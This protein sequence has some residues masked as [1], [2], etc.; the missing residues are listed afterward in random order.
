MPRS[1]EQHVRIAVRDQVLGGHE[2]LLD[3]RA[4]TALQQHG[5]SAAAERFQQREVLHVAGPDLHDVGVVGDQLHVAVAHDFGD[6]EQAGRV[7]GFLQQLQAVDFHALEIVGRGARLV[8]AAPQD[9]RAGGR[10]RFGRLH[11]LLLG[12]NRAGTRHDDELV[13][14]DFEIADSHLR[15]LLLEFLADEFVGR[16]NADGPFNAGSG[17]QGLEARGHVAHPHH[18]N[19]HPLLAFDRV[20]SIAKIANALAD[21]IYFRLGSVRPHRDNHENVLFKYKNPLFR[22]GWFLLTC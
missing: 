17:F 15:A 10:H 13:A 6:D 20:N 7:L 3:G 22:V 19:H 16:G 8:G 18:A 4:E 12:F 14:P 5:T 2:Q 9:L 21:V 1:T 11:D